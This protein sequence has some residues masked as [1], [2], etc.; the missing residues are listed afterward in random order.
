VTNQQLLQRCAHPGDRATR[1][2]E[3]QATAY[4]AATAGPGRGASFSPTRS[5]RASVRHA[6]RPPS[7]VWPRRAPANHITN[8]SVLRNHHERLGS[9]QQIFGARRGTCFPTTRSLVTL[10]AHSA[11]TKH[12]ACG[13]KL[14][15]V[16][17][18]L[19][20]HAT[21]G[22]GRV[23]PEV[24]LPAV[25]LV[26]CRLPS[27]QIVGC[28]LPILLPAVPWPSW[29]GHGGRP[30]GPVH[31]CLFVVSPGHPHLAPAHHCISMGS[32][33]GGPARQK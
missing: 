28:V 32:S 20:C 2:R 10:R 33:V 24:A 14:G 22:H 15:R 31:P 8:G 30:S 3:D 18:R 12:R 11:S 23:S 27:Y 9:T 5:I 1:D 26:G 17:G 6:A 16:A 7:A 19:A 25:S 4:P 29:W 13:R 21:Q